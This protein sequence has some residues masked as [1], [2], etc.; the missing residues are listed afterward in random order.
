[1]VGAGDVAD[2]LADAL[3]ASDVAVERA[4][5]PAPAKTGAQEIAAIAKS[6]LELEDLLAEDGAGAVLLASR[7]GTALAA[8]LV[9]TKLGLPTAQ[10]EPLADQGG[11]E[12]NARLIGQL[13][14]KKLAV[15]A[16]G[17][18]AWLCDAYTS[19]P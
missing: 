11:D 13:A 14:D 8:L 4:P 17:I 19:A 9:A 12:I 7:S 5:D 16:D 18:V 15:D 2:R 3:A 1:M 10:L 6:L